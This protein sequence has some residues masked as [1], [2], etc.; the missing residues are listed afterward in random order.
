MELYCFCRY[1]IIRNM[2]TNK[3]KKQSYQAVLASVKKEM[4]EPRVVESAR[5]EA[6]RTCTATVKEAAKP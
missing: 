5:I 1:D 3:A 2:S 6:E 4:A